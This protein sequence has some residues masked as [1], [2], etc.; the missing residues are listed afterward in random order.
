M[1]IKN[2]IAV[3]TG[4]CLIITSLA[5][6]ATVAWNNSR[7]KDQTEAMVHREL[8]DQAYSQLAAMAESEA[9]KTADELNKT[10]FIIRGMADTMNSFIDQYGAKIERE[11]FYQYTRWIMQEHDHLLGAYFAWQKNAVDGR[12]QEFIGQG[13]TH[14]NGQYT[15]FWYRE[16]DGTLGTRPLAMD[17]VEEAIATGDIFAKWWTCPIETREPCISEPY[18]WEAG[19]RTVVGTSITM[20]LILAGNVLG[21]AGADIELTFLTVLAQRAD[22]GLYE[23]AGSVMLLS[24]E[25]VVAAH[26]D[27][28][29]SLGSV[30][31]GDE[32]QRLRALTGKGE[33][34]VFNSKGKYWAVQPVNLEGISKPWVVVISLDEDIVLQRADSVLESMSDNFASSM[35]LMFVISLLITVGSIFVLLIIARSLAAPIRQATE[36]IAGLAYNDGDLTQR[37][38]IQRS[39]EIGELADGINAFIAKTQVIVKD[40]SNEMSRVEEAANRAANISNAST[41]G[42][43]KQRMEVDMITTAVGEMA[44]SAGEVAKI[45]TTTASASGEAK[46]SVDNSAANVQASVNAM[47]RLSTQISSTSSLLDELAQDSENINRIVETIQ[48]IS[49]QT[50]LLALNAAIEAARAGESGRGFAVVADEVRSLASKTQLSTT[51]IQTLIDHLQARTRASV[52]AMLEGSEQSDKCLELADE[53]SSDLQQVVGAVSE[54]DQMTTQMASIVE[55]QR[56]VTEDVTGSVEKISAETTKI[57]DGALETNHESQELLQLVIRLEDQLKRFR[58]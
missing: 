4:T 22:K 39:D 51:E 49:E 12:D 28:A 20:P 47:R 21:I 56:A 9:S 14:N 13:H 15:P 11:P 31:K 24:A 41:H 40:I 3:A 8:Q 16:T 35:M 34:T 58:C 1:K 37:L 30:Y 10:L 43:E 6:L 52:E 33:S 42:I 45:A 26:S 5:M 55:E 2:R 25:G 57:F 53:A 38:N 23:G 19:S 54:I 29:K 7:V 48:G 36:M 32:S 27:D 46:T 44:L 50:N 17:K 18:S